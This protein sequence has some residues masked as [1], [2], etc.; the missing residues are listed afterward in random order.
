MKLSIIGTSKLSK[1][2]Y[3]IQFSDG[4][5]LGIKYT[6]KTD[7]WDDYGPMCSIGTNSFYLE[8]GYFPKG[9]NL[10]KRLLMGTDIIKKRINRYK[11]DES[12]VEPEG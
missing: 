7:T 1:D 6:G 10:K 8:R 11:K 5:L 12:N 2:T 9:N 3:S 4:I